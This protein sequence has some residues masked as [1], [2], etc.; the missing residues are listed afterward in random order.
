MVTVTGLTV[1]DAVVR[2][3]TAEGGSVLA[4]DGGRCV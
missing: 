4:V 2:Y 3:A 1:T